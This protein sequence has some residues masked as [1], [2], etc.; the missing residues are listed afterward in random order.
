MY[1]HTV[2]V[3]TCQAAMEAPGQ[4]PVS[5]QVQLFPASLHVCPQGH[6]QSVGRL[7]GGLG[8][9][10]H[11]GESRWQELLPSGRDCSA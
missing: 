5:L 6:P 9:G 3:H 7:G 1:T 4:A 8:A 11:V 2:G 10:V